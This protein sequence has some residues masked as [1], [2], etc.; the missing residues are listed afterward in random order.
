MNFESKFVLEN[1]EL[2]KTTLQKDEDV[3]AYALRSLLFGMINSPIKSN[4]V[5]II[6]VHKDEERNV[7]NLHTKITEGTYFNT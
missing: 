6:G 7:T 2:L 4:G 1:P 5:Q 3:Q